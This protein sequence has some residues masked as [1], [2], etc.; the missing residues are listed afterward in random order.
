MPVTYAQGNEYSELQE[1]PADSEVQDD[2][3][4]PTDSDEP[5]DT[6]VLTDSDEPDDTDVQ[7]EVELLDDADAA[8]EDITIP[9]STETDPEPAKNEYVWHDSFSLHKI[10]NDTDAESARPV[11]KDGLFQLYYEVLDYA[12]EEIPTTGYKAFTEENT[13]ADFGEDWWKTGVDDSKSFP[14]PSITDDDTGWT[15]CYDNVL[16]EQVTVQGK[17][18]A[19]RLH[20]SIMQSKR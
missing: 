6:N 11:E 18:T 17:M 16:P 19:R 5:D 4:A 12:T 15:Y 8:E 14:A 13:K 3:N 9:D 1:A 7:E 2:T 20:M 10:W